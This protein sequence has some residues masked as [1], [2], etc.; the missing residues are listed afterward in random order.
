MNIKYSGLL[1]KILRGFTIV[2]ILV[3]LLVLSLGLLGIAGLQAS[4]SVY[5]MNSWTISAASLLASD[6]SDRVKANPSAAGTPFLDP[7][8]VTG[9]YVFQEKFNS[10]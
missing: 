10:Q 2:E 7:F 4:T 9:Q 1:V 5:K 6:F 3:S 8:P